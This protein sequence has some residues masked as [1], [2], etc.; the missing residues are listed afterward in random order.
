M[1]KAY[2]IPETEIL[3]MDST[4]LMQASTLSV[5]D[6]TV[7]K[8]ETLGRELDDIMDVEF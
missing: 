5:Y 4:D 7:G 6:D 8:E 2:Q 3:L 1:K